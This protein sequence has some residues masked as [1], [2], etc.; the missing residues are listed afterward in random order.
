MYVVNN[1]KDHLLI[2]KLKIDG[3]ECSLNTELSL[4]MNSLD[5][6]DCLGS[7]TTSTP[8]II[9]TAGNSLLEKKVFIKDFFLESVISN[10]FNSVHVLDNPNNYSTSTDDGFGN[11]VSIVSERNSRTILF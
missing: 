7:I 6:S 2:T 11:T 8:N 3:V 4:G 5:V 1:V 10:N 9:L